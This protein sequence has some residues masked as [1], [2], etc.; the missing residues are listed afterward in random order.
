MFHCSNIPLFL[1]RVIVQNDGRRIF[2]I[3]RAVYADRRR[4]H[5]YGMIPGMH[6]LKY[7]CREHVFLSHV[8][9]QVIPGL[10][11]ADQIRPIFSKRAPVNFL[12]LEDGL[13]NRFSLFIFE[14][15]ED[16]LDFRF[17][18]SLLAE[19]DVTFR[20]FVL[21]MKV[22][23][24]RVHRKGDRSRGDLSIKFLRGIELERSLAAEISI[25]IDLFF[26]ERKTMVR[27]EDEKKVLSPLFF[28]ISNKSQMI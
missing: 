17:H 6:S 10:W 4:C 16:L 14:V 27:E 21:K 15:P 13:E 11:K 22:D 20:K 8:T 1:L 9:L 7:V 19:L 28:A 25:E 2:D 18:L 3:D 12:L 5:E 24:A 26:E 23:S